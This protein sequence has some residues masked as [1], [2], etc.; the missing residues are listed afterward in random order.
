M[1][2][3]ERKFMRLMTDR[4][5]QYDDA[6][7]DINAFIKK[8]P[9]ECRVCDAT[10]S[11]FVRDINVRAPACILCPLAPCTAGKTFNISDLWFSANTFAWSDSRIKRELKARR[12]WL[13]KKIQKKGYDYV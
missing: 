7:D 1:K 4:L 10:P 11:L 13:I 2:F 6:L 12:G 9:E 8:P 5:R 3:D